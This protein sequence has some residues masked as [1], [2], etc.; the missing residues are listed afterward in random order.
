[1]L[2]LLPPLTSGIGVRLKGFEGVYSGNFKTLSNKNSNTLKRFF[3]L[4]LVHSV[5]DFFPC[6]SADRT[7]TG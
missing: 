6:I 7:V 2:K 3:S 1:M 5:D 4:Q